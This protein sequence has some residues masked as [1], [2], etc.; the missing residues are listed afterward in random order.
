MAPEAASVVD[1][2][3]VPFETSKLPVVPGATV[4]KPLVPLPISTALAAKVERPVPPSA[5]AK[6]VIPEIVPPVIATALAFWLDI[7]PKVP[8]AVTTAALTK[9]VVAICVVF[10]PLA[11]LGAVG[12]P[13]NVG[14]SADKVPPTVTFPLVAKEV[15]KVVTSTTFVASLNTT[16]VLPGGTAIPVPAVFLTVTASASSFLIMYCFS[17]CKPVPRTNC[18]GPPEVPTRTKRKLRAG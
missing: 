1:A 10:V 11:A 6:L 2:Q 5:T 8:V 13:V 14:E 9:A 12:T 17:I 16:I 4:F 3:A 18:L 7:V 15:T